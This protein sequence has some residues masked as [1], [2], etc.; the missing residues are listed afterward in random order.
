MANRF[1]A[2]M[3]NRFSTSMTNR[4]S[5]S[6]ADRFSTLVTYH[7]WTIRCRLAYQVIQRPVSY[8]WQEEKRTHLHF[9]FYSRAVRVCGT[10]KTEELARKEFEAISGNISN[11][12][13]DKRTFGLL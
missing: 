3:T 13:D 10:E 6:M 1:S 9:S 2:P 11:E 4:S 8:H 12:S 7:S 5:T